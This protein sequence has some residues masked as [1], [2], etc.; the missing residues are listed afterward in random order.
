VAGVCAWALQL[1]TKGLS[2]RPVLRQATA[3]GLLWSGLVGIVLPFLVRRRSQ[4][5]IDHNSSSPLSSP[6]I[7]IAI[8]V[9]DR[10]CCCYFP[11]KLSL[12]SHG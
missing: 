5:S 2:M 3:G 7:L 4:P 12:I 8:I 11:S 10:C 6:T 9:G 1:P